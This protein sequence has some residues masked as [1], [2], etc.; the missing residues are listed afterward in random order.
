MAGGRKTWAGVAIAA[1]GLGLLFVV[2]VAVV[3]SRPEAPPTPDPTP[4][5]APSAEWTD[6]RRLEWLV[7]QGWT[8]SQM[9][10]RECTPLTQC[11]NL[12]T[13]GELGA[14]MT[15]AGIAPCLDREREGCAELHR[16]LVEGDFP[17]P[18]PDFR[19]FIDDYI[20]VTAMELCET[21]L[22][23]RLV[24]EHPEVL[25]RLRRNA[26]L[27]EPSFREHATGWE[28]LESWVADDE[29]ARPA[30]AAEFS[31]AYL[32]CVHRHPGANRTHIMDVMPWLR[33]RYDC[34]P[35]GGLCTLDRAHEMAV[36]GLPFGPAPAR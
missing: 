1:A 31:Q 5:T 21:D 11:S 17:A 23:R 33:A 16:V 9:V 18:P 25:D 3:A 12:L 10:S 24:R 8:V 28:S 36:R 20:D 6:Q 35:V 13:P 27:V 4:S 15:P 22:D 32:D 30:W 34:R 14:P 2:V 26:E 19:G 7:N 29:E